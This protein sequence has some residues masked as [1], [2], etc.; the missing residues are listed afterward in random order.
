MS[1]VSQ[2]LPILDEL[3]REFRAL[4]AAELGAHRPE[5]A[6]LP[7]R[8]R[9][10]KR[11]RGAHRIARRAT[12]V[13]VLLCLVGGVALAARF[14]VGSSGNSLHTSP[15]LLGRSGTQ[16]WSVSA[17]RDRGRLCLL[18]HRGADLTSQCGSLLAPDRLRATSLLT[19][20]HRF[21]VG[22]SGPGVAAVTVKV[23]GQRAS[24]PAR[25]A[26]DPAA[27]R[28]AHIPGG[29][30][31]FAVPLPPRLKG[32]ATVLGHD[33]HGSA[34]GPAYVDCSLGV[35]SPLCERAIRARARSDTP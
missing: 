23:G 32:P 28:S 35:T 34:S 26:G 25:R 18:F 21:V 4:V 30:R 5:R 24:R 10:S 15:T 6:R 17:Y 12:V 9:P 27:A 31:W 7:Q 13:L 19:G 8:A 11:E 1:N 20:D 2:D 3:G 16:G 33:S 29:T 14:G 22:L